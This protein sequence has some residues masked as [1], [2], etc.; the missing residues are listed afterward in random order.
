MTLVGLGLTAWTW[1]S[2]VVREQYGM[3]AAI[4]GPVA[5]VLGLGM[6]LNGADMPLDGITQLTRRWGLAGSVAGIV[7][8]Y[9]LGFFDR[10][11]R[12]AA[13]RYVDLAVPVVMILVWFLPDRFYG[14]PGY[15]VPADPS[16]PIEPR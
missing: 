16:E 10:A 15:V 7:N 13:A 4:L 12:S 2:A 11:H 6:L 1:Q 5:V 14:G 8:L 9:L 3:K